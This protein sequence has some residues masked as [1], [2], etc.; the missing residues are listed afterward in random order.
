[1]TQTKD[2]PLLFS[3]FED[4]AKSLVI[5]Y[6]RSGGLK[7]SKNVGAVR[8][9]FCINFLKAVIPSRFTIYQ[10]GEIIDSK[11]HNTGEVDITILRDDCPKLTY[12]ETDV[13]LAE[14]VFAVI[15]VKS[16]LSREKF[17]ESLNKLKAV[18]EL[19]PN[20]HRVMSSGANLDRPLRCVF[21]YEGATFKTLMDEINKFEDGDIVDYIGVLNRGAVIR[22]GHLLKWDGDAEYIQ[23]NGQ[24]ASITFLYYHLIQY[25]TSVMARNLQFT[26]YFEPL[27]NWK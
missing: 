2:T 26:N 1:M 3:Y 17:N 23:I 4:T 16:N 5:D 27:N 7:A 9:S 6:Q 12:G 22:K 15:D 19:Q 14:G 11:G 24:A 20:V 8:E 21:A 10:G 25:G 18:K 13:Y